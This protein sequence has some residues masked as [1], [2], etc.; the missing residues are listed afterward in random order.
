MVKPGIRLAWDV[1]GFSSSDRSVNGRDRCDEERIRRTIDR[2]RTRAI[3]N[4]HDAQYRI[5]VHD[6][7]DEVKLTE[8]LDHGSAVIP[9]SSLVDSVGNEIEQDHSRS[10]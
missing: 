6:K 9:L 10:W 5:C 1:G 7:R 2:S 3:V 8:H 4:N